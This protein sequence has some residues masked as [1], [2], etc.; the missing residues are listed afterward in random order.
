MQWI[1]Y[2]QARH[3]VRVGWPHNQNDGPTS[4]SAWVSPCDEGADPG[5]S[6]YG[7][8]NDYARTAHKHEHEVPYGSR[9]LDALSCLP[10]HNYLCLILKYS[11]TKR[12]T[13]KRNC[14]SKFKG[15]ARLLRPAWIRH[16]D[17]SI[18]F[19]AHFRHLVIQ[20]H[21]FFIQ[22]R[23]EKLTVFNSKVQFRQIVIHIRFLAI[24]F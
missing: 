12:Y 14:W 15:A 5:F 20:F 11:V 23:P 22:F 6:K 18:G 4:F 7:S 17:N 13:Q 2:H 21:P 8:A 9:F 3:K 1:I 24:K 10:S 16:R 19:P